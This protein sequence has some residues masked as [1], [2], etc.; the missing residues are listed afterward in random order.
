MSNT[1]SRT[2]QLAHIA[3]IAAKSKT[4]DSDVL[5]FKGGVYKGEWNP[6]ATPNTFPNNTQAHDIFLVSHNG[7]YYG[8]VLAVGELVRFVS[9]HDPILVYSKYLPIPFFLSMLESEPPINSG[10]GFAYGGEWDA[11]P[12]LMT[13]D[14]TTFDTLINAAFDND[15]LT[16]TE[17]T[18]NAIVYRL[19]KQDSGTN[20]HFRFVWPDTTSSAFAVCFFQ[21]DLTDFNAI[22]ADSDSAAVG[23][24][25][26]FANNIHI[27]KSVGNATSAN[28]L[29]NVSVGDVVRFAYRAAT[30]TLYVYNETEANTLLA[31]FALNLHLDT[32]KNMNL[33]VGL[34]G[35]ESLECT[36]DD[37]GDYPFQQDLYLFEYPSDLTKTYKVS[38]ATADSIINHK[39]LKTNDFVDFISDDDVV[40]DVIVSRLITDSEINQKIGQK[41]DQEI[42]DGLQNPA[43]NI[44]QLVYGI[45]FQTIDEQCQST[46]LIDN[47]IQ[48]A[49]ND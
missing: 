42:F 3:S 9:Q 32:S 33:L 5:F 2:Q 25:S 45:V 24:G 44:Y 41:I 31:T 14:V 13:E 29:S 17:N 20:R 30:N 36:F 26:Q 11:T 34:I 8:R 1:P 7:A 39:L 22:F 21:S 28:P 10:G 49:V 6:N 47:A 38:A 4:E 43:S 48:S 37:A 27:V 46:G 19:S 40:S 18:A 15:T 16:T 23:V 12:N 35:L